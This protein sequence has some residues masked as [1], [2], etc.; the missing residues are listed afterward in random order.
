MKILQE[1][2]GRLVRLLERIIMFFKRKR[3]T[4]AELI[5][6][7]KVLRQTV[8]EVKHAQDSGSNWYTHGENGLRRQ[9]R[10]HIDKACKAIKSIEADLET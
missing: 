3:A 1:T 6:A 10:L 9:V 7:I 8:Y 5:A 2:Y 4:R